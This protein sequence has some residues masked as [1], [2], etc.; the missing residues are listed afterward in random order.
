[1]LSL[2]GELELEMFEGTITSLDCLA[3]TQI[4][5]SMTLPLTSTNLT[6]FFAEP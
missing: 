2:V 3:K 4:V 5:P 1:M 6:S